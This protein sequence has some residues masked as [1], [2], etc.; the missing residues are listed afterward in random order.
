MVSSCLPVSS[1][2]P[3]PALPTPH[4]QLRT[5][6]HHIWGASFGEYQKD[7]FSGTLL[8]CVCVSHHRWCHTCGL[9]WQ[10]AHSCHC[11]MGPAV[12]LL[13]CVVPGSS[14][15]YTGNYELCKKG[16]KGGSKVVAQYDRNQWQ[17]TIHKCSYNRL[18]YSSMYVANMLQMHVYK[19]QVL[20]NLPCVIVY[21]P[22]DAHVVVHIWSTPQ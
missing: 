20:D 7:P 16:E 4:N 17:R 3:S 15:E 21:I 5:I 9:T 8:L 13:G 18:C 2:T 1:L 6:M 22:H 10:P 19:W 11:H 14:C 12:P